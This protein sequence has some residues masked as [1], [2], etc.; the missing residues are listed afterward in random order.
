MMVGMAHGV[1]V[2]IP[3]AQHA[4]DVQEESIEC[5][6]FENRAVAQFVHRDPL[7]EGSHRAV[8]DQR[9]READP[10]LLCPKVI[11]ECPGGGPQ[12][13]MSHRLKS[14]TQVAALHELPK[15]VTLDR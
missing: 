11:G 8:Q 1:F 6:R 3:P 13:Q 9:H 5:P 14:A 7:E 15:Y 10:Y 12:R 2:K 4:I